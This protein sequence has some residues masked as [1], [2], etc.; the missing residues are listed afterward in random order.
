MQVQK[1]LTSPKKVGVHETLIIEQLTRY[2]GEKGY[3]MVSHVQLNISYGSILSELDMLLE[4]NGL[5]TYVEVK[6]HKDKLNHAF[7][8]INRVKDYVDYSYVAT[9]RRLGDWAYSTIGLIVVQ[10]EKVGIVKH[11][12]RLTNIPRYSALFS[13]RKKCLR[14]FLKNGQIC[15]DRLSKH[16]LARYVFFQRRNEVSRE[17]LKE[18]VTCGKQ[19]CLACPIPEFAA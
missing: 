14:Q 10:E 15:K 16:E 8:Q 17:C 9:N 3:K 1:M 4:K 7:E 13:L 6:S 5:L 18:I 12:K 11:A 2:F 19:S